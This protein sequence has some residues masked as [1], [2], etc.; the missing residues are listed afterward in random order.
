MGKIK[1]GLTREILL[2]WARSGFPED[3]GIF[4]ETVECKKLLNGKNLDIYFKI[5][6]CVRFES[7]IIF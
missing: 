3:A 6:D 1:G 2:T 4:E 7:R 5:A